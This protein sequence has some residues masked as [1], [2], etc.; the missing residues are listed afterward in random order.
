MPLNRETKGY[1]SKWHSFDK[2]PTFVSERARA[3]CRRSGRACNVIGISLPAVDVEIKQKTV[4][5]VFTFRQIRIYIYVYHI[6]LPPL[7]VKLRNT[8]LKRVFFVI[9][10]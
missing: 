1:R 4:N 8:N 2:N 10:F 3:R 9:V 5:A 6:C 7:P